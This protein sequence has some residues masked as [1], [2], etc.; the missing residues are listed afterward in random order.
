MKVVH[1]L[2]IHQTACTVI[3]Q[4]LQPTLIDSSTWTDP[5][6]DRIFRVEFFIPKAPTSGAAEYRATAF[7][8]QLSLSHNFGL[9]NASDVKERHSF[10][11]TVH[12]WLAIGY[13]DS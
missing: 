3:C 2:L 5:Y 7:H 8:R 1:N 11:Q 9:Q 4:P 6:V 13:S 12:F 10:V